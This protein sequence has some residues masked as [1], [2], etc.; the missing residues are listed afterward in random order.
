MTGGN[1][2]EMVV[3]CQLVGQRH[4]ELQVNRLRDS[5]VFGVV[6]ARMSMSMSR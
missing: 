2:E 1:S 3:A 6:A 5:E 4:I